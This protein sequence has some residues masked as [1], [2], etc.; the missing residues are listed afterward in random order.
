MRRRKNTGILV[1]LIILAFMAF[2]I[3]TQSVTQN[4]QVRQFTNDLLRAY[5]TRDNNTLRDKYYKDQGVSSYYYQL[6]NKFTVL[7]WEITRID[8]Q[9]FPVNTQG[10]GPGGSYIYDTVHVNVYYQPVDKLVQPKGRY[11]RI[12]HAKYGDCMVVPVTISY[13]Y[14]P[15]HDPEW[16]IQPP[17][18]DSDAFWVLPYEKPLAS[19]FDA[20]MRQ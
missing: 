17:A 12:K 14:H 11:Q 19:G 7:G 18:I 5:Q 10:F 15:N 8:G 2:T 1:L 9:P 20:L 3:I 16:F 6:L 4:R 13:S